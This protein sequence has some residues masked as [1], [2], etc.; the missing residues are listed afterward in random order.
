[1][2]RLLMIVLWPSFLVAIVAEGLFF[3]LIDPF[4]GSLGDNEDSLSPLATYTI[5]FFL[6]WLFCALSSSLTCYLG[7]SR[8]PVQKKT[9]HSARSEKA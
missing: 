2:P 5:G 1:M 8:A 4:G 7:E 3:S 6:L 9:D